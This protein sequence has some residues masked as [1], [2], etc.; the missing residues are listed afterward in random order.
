MPR[1][2][3][4]RLVGSVLDCAIDLNFAES[5]SPSDNSIAA[6]TLPCPSTSQSYS[7]IYRG[8][9]TQMNPSL[10]TTFMESIVY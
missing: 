8:L 9:K 3:S 10:V 2:R 4:T 5:A 7:S 6:A 1:A